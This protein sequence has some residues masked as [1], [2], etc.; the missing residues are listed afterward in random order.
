MA[1]LKKARVSKASTIIT[2]EQRLPEIEGR[3]PYTP[4]T[5]HLI[6]DGKGGYLVEN[7]RRPSKTLLVNQIRKFLIVGTAAEFDDENL[8]YI[9][10]IQQ[11]NLVWHIFELS[12][13]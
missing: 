5:Q 12:V 2:L 1:S 11:E 9:A 4:P 13:Q 10:T 6:K 3:E 7:F 8:K